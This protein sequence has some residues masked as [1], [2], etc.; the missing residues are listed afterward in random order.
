MKNSC[1]PTFSEYRDEIKRIASFENWP[2]G[3]SQKHD[4]M[5]KSGFFYTGQSD[6]VLCF[7][8]GGCLRDWEQTDVPDEE[9]AIWYSNCEYLK[10]LKGEKFVNNVLKR[11]TEILS[12]KEETKNTHKMMEETKAGICVIC[13]VN[14]YNFAFLP[15]GHLALCKTCVLKTKLNNCLLC[16]HKVKKIVQIFFA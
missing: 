6:R 15:C 9:H 2:K 4:E 10:Q 8:C 7:F 13:L 16:K 3:L 11:K 1:S 5:A 14:P 12:N